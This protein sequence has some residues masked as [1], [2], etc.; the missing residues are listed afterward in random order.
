MA[1]SGAQNWRAVR[2]CSKRCCDASQ[3]WIR[4]LWSS[5]HVLPRIVPL[6]ILCESY[7]FCGDMSKKVWVRATHRAPPKARPMS[8]A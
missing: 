4:E 7:G 6:H 5:C 1:E 2:V 8:A 3:L